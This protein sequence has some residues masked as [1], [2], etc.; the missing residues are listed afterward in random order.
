MRAGLVASLLAT[1]AQADEPLI[2]RFVEETEPSGVVSS[3][4]GGWEY[5]VGGGVAAFDCSGDGFPDLAL[6]GGEAPASLWRNLSEPGGPLR[7]ERA[8][9]GI[10]LEAVT[11]DK[12]SNYFLTLHLLAEEGRAED[13]DEPDRADPDPGT[14]TAKR[15]W[16]RRERRSS[17]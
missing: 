15:R 1:A 5:M 12:T 16:L 9:S 7:F 3:Y 8:D 2:P 13:F 11:G 6:A 17:T 10:E 14:T 4:D